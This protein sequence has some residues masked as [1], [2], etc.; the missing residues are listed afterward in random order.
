VA[1]CCECGDEPSGYCAMELVSFFFNFHDWIQC[2]ILAFGDESCQMLS[3]ILE[4][5]A[6]AFSG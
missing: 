3:N 6:F 4:N 1:G 2:T 5:V